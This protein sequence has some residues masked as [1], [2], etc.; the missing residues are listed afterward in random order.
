MARGREGA[1]AQGGAT[2]AI[3]MELIAP[4]GDATARGEIPRLAG[5][6]SR[7]W[8]TTSSS[9]GRNGSVLERVRA[10][11]ASTISLGASSVALWA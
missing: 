7:R 5:D 6:R 10:A 4:E 8:S 2:F 1:G 3:R 9:W 11:V